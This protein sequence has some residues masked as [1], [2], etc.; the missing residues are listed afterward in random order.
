MILRILKMATE[1]TVLGVFSLTVICAQQPVA[2][3]SATQAT[4]AGPQRPRPPQPQ[5]SNQQSPLTNADVVKMVKGGVPTSAIIS[6][7]QSSP[8]KFDLSNEAKAALLA[9]GGKNRINE[10]TDIWDTI[11]ARATNGRGGADAGELNPQPLP[12][13]GKGKEETTAQGVDPSITQ[14]LP[15]GAKVHL[16]TEDEFQKL[17]A[18]SPGAPPKGTQSSVA[19]NPNASQGGSSLMAELASQRQAAEADV[20]Q[21]KAA[22]PSGPMQTMSASTTSSGQ[23]GKPNVAATQAS[24]AKPAAA[25]I[26]R[27]AQMPNV[28]MNGCYAI[29]K[30][31]P[32]ISNVNGQPHPVTFTPVSQYNLYTIHGCNFGDANPGAKAWIFGLGFHA[33]FEVEEWLD[34]AIVVKLGEN[35]SGVADQDNLHV[36][37]H[38]ADGKEAQAD[39]YKFYAAR[40]TVL[41]KYIPPAWRKLDYTVT[42]RHHWDWHPSV[43]DNSPVGGPNVPSQA[44]GTTIYVSRR[45]AD[46]FAPSTDSFD[47]SQLPKGWVVESASWINFPANCPNVVTYRENFGQWN[48]QWNATGI[49]FS[50]S[51]TSCSGFWPNP[52]LGF[53]TSAYQDHTESNYAITV[54]VS[55]PRG[56]ESDLPHM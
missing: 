29:S 41:L 7:I 19:K 40:E 3:P 35:I 34:D 6:S 37:V 14:K 56:R 48:L 38:R 54:M 28:K 8:A 30:G 50:W 49:Q 9:A 13:R 53:P 23:G 52:V 44:N 32:M 51:D 5:S 46:K 33:D 16:L 2:S 36:V 18:Q 15:K 42:G 55:G 12:P 24:G 26:S 27:Y 45:L 25:G 1:L 43:Q 22:H 39:G 4:P 47:F 10:M 20:L 31:Q 21:I 11:V 17:V